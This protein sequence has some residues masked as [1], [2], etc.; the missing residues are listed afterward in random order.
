MLYK[1]G[2]SCDCIIRRTSNVIYV[3]M[4]VPLLLYG[5][6]SWVTIKKH[7]TRIQTLQKRFLQSFECSRRRDNNKNVSK[8]LKILNIKDCIAI[9]K[10][11]CFSN[12]NIRS[13]R[14]SKEDWER[15]ACWRKKNRKT[16]EALVLSLIHI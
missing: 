8:N 7:L 4:A 2:L 3:V 11:R 6:Q 13:G 15:Q 5:S 12:L 1:K 10:E 16:Y 9:N 14:S